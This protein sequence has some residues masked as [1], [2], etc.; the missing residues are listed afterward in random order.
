MKIKYTS[1]AEPW[2]YYTLQDG[3]E[4]KV[5]TVLV[6]ASRRDGEYA[7]DGS[8]IYDMNFQNIVNVDAPD[9]LKLRPTV[10]HVGSA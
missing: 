7:P 9:E 3:T 8:P 2:T 1:S 4:V 10:G 5:K 6:S